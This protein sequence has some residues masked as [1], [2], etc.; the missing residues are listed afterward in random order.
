MLSQQKGQNLRCP[1]HHWM[2]ALIVS[3]RCSH[4][5]LQRKMDCRLTLCSRPRLS[6]SPEE[7]AARASRALVARDTRMKFGMVHAGPFGD[8]PRRAP[9]STQ[10][11]ERR[12]EQR[13]SQQNV[14]TERS[15]W[16]MYVR[17]CVCTKYLRRLLEAINFSSG[18][19]MPVSCLR[20]LLLWR[21]HRDRAP[22]RTS[23]GKSGSLRLRQI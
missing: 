2:S 12:E 5:M 15:Q 8:L 11:A 6:G 16:C 1:F 7:L 13:I 9:S 23:D 18:Y 22:L 20:P 14:R 17:T 19:W 4:Q 3:R 21:H 10:Q